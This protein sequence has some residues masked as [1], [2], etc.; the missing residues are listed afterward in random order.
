[1]KKGVYPYALFTPRNV[2]ILLRHKVKEELDRMQRLRVIS[3][4][5]KPTSWCTGM[6]VV[7]RVRW[8]E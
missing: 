5:T 2:P 6:V 7:P 1:M 8:C 4:V 3:R